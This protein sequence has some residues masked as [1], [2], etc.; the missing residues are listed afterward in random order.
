M[1]WIPKD[2]GN[3]RIQLEGSLSLFESILLTHNSSLGLFNSLG[4]EYYRIFVRLIRL[5]VSVCQVIIGMGPCNILVIHLI[6]K[7]SESMDL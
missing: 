1:I 3:R 5:I 6:T 2:T 7:K 4:T